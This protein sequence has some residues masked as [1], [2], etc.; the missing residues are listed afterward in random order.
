MK[1]L[2]LI[3][4]ISSIFVFGDKLESAKLSGIWGSDLSQDKLNKGD[5]LTFVKNNNRH[6]INFKPSGEVMF[7]TNK[8]KP[9]TCGVLAD[10]TTIRKPYWTTIGEW[11]VDSNRLNFSLYRGKGCINFL[12]LRLIYNDE[13]QLKFVIESNIG[14]RDGRGAFK[15]K[16]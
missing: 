7:F 10:T 4:A 12:D 13:K 2:F 15:R 9:F 16:F 11:T 1:S 6:Q 14:L 3:I 5:T 8:L